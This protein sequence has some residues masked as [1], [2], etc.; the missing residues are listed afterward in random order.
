MSTP[1]SAQG[2][3]HGNVR[4]DES[5]V[6]WTLRR[7]FA[8]GETIACGGV[9]SDRIAE[10]VGYSRATVCRRLSTLE[11][12]GE[13][14]QVPG[15]DN[16]RPRESYQPADSDWPPEKASER[17]YD[18]PEAPHLDGPDEPTT[19]AREADDDESADGRPEDGLD[20][21]DLTLADIRDAFDVVWTV[22]GGNTV[23]PRE[24]CYHIS[25]EDQEPDEK[26]P[27][28]LWDTTPVCSRCYRVATGQQSPIRS[29]IIERLREAD[30]GWVSRSELAPSAEVHSVNAQLAVLRE[31][32]R[33]ETRQ[34]RGSEPNQHRLIA[35]SD[36]T[37]SAA[38]MTAD[39]TT[40]TTAEDGQ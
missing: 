25:G 9:T 18:L 23:H 26:N 11:D 1:S 10:E 31:A 3:R 38:S 24:D 17:D 39:T 40:T 14:T 12:A 22:P 36:E 2:P 28:H 5:T 32:G 4:L 8:T 30:G 7:L 34:T 16:G 13:V 21:S 27:A 29:S 15:L 19:D 6:L 33:I 20:L 35:N 37:D